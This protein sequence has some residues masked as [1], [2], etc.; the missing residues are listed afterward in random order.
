M[1]IIYVTC[2]RSELYELF[3]YLLGGHTTI[4]NSNCPGYNDRSNSYIHK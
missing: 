4:K 1:F 3:T 2:T